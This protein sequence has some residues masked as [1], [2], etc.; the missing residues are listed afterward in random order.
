MFPKENM[1]SVI[2]IKHNMNSTFLYLVSQIFKL[3]NAIIYQRWTGTTARISADD[4]KLDKNSY[5]AF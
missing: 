1:F 3:Y 2:F 4:I 5:I